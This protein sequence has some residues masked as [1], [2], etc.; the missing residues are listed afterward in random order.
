LWKMR[1]MQRSPKCLNYTMMAFQLCKNYLMLCRKFWIWLELMYLIG[2]FRLL[3]RCWVELFREFGSVKCYVVLC[4]IVSNDSRMVMSIRQCNMWVPVHYC[5][6][7]IVRNSKVVRAVEVIESEFGNKDLPLPPSW[8]QKYG[9]GRNLF[10]RNTFIYFTYTCV[11]IFLHCL[12][13]SLFV[14]YS[15]H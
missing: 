8:W 3:P 14:T 12:F 5:W 15:P 7:V 10:Y 6:C 4:D 1:Q 11:R 13:R 9:W 2:C